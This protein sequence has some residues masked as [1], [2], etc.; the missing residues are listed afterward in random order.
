[1]AYKT[2][3]AGE[4]LT[5]SDVNTYLMKQSV[6]VCTSATR[7]S[8]PNEG[9]TIYETDTDQLLIYN[10]SAW[11]TISHLA[12]WTTF[13]PTLAG[14]GW[15]FGSPTVTG[16]Y[17]RN[18][19]K[20]TYQGRIVWAGGVTPDATNTFTITLPVTAASF[21]TDDWQGVGMIQD[22]SG[23]N[24]YYATQ[25]YLSSTTVMVIRAHNVTGSLIRMLPANSTN[26]GAGSFPNTFDSG[27]IWTWTIV[28]EAA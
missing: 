5:A 7:P 6:I 25:P 12:G 28:Y 13:T 8:G 23:S 21:S 17:H 15:T 1:M 2:F 22:V 20:I 26:T 18:G 10:G 3:T 19:S 9:M 27:D 16:Q 4:V 11:E 14:T 24:L